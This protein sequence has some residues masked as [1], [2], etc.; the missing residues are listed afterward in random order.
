MKGI[1]VSMWNGQNDFARAKKDSIDFAIIR[2]SFGYNSDDFHYGGLDNRFEENYRGCVKN[3]ILTGVYHYS[4]AQTVEQARKE[5]Y[6]T[7]SV[8][9]GRK[10]DMPVF[11]DVEDEFIQQG[12]K[13]VTERI[14]AYT[15]IIKKNGYIAG[16][17]ANQYW[18]DNFIDI[19]KLPNDI[20]KWIARYNKLLFST[21]PN[22]YNGKFDI[23]QYGSYGYKVDGI[24]NF[25]G[26]INYVDMN[27][28]YKDYKNLEKPK[29]HKNP[30]FYKFGYMHTREEAVFVL[31]VSS[32][33]VRT[34][35]TRESNIVS[36]YVKGER[37]NYD[38]FVVND[39]HV[40]I[41][42]I[43]DSGRRRYVAI[44]EH[45]GTK[46]TSLWGYFK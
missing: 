38:S 46:R 2:C 29:P 8:L 24:S 16:V 12:N 36:S 14:L 3:E 37:I 27:I 44:G 35:P 45:N 11:Y 22:L 32:I 17:Y 6:K 10:L 41:S 43:A 23:W 30:V 42:Y 31:E 25:G 4:Y 21:N 39:N 9:K 5:A 40:W 15:E 19:S 33:N 26:G 7:L 1:D 20:D 13:D 34:L 18:Y 28:A